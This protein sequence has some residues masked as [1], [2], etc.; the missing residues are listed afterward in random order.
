M[1]TDGSSNRQAGGAGVVLLSPE[2][3]VV[4]CMIYLDFPTTNKE[5]EYEALVAGLD[6]ARAAGATS[7]VIYYDS[8]VITNQVNGDYECKG[9][10]MKLYLDQVKMR[11]DDLQAKIIQIPRGENEQ[12]DRLAKAASA[13]HMITHGNVLSFV[14]LSPLIDSSDVHEIGSK[15]NWIITIAS[16]LKDG[17]LPD[18]KE[19]A[20]KLKVQAARFVLIK[21]VLYK[22]GFSC[23][24]LRCL[25]NEETD[26]VMKG[27]HEG[28]CRNHSE[29]RSL[30]HKLVRAGYYWPTIQVDA[31]GY[32]KACDKCQKFSNI[33]W[34]P[35]EELALMT[36]P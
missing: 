15:S 35:T 27:V 11:V 31:E 5:A 26:Y 21:D 29:S 22:R 24:Y 28:I 16:Y 10:R 17:I 7:V 19:A 6:L 9:K 14:Q 36:A 23:P 8:Q 12:A 13:E 34:Q 18:E 4:E 25:G 2:E 3:D 20:R 33:I 32:V 30:V 1:H